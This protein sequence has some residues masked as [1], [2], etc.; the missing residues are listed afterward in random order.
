MTRLVAFVGFE[1]VVL[2]LIGYFVV[3]S[4]LH[5]PKRSQTVKAPVAGVTSVPAPNEDGDSEAVN[6]DYFAAT[7][8]RPRPPCQSSIV[9]EL[10][11]TLRNKS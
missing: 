5:S 10:H 7:T 9:A 11:L 8:G 6:P 2:G 1:L 4:F 3:R